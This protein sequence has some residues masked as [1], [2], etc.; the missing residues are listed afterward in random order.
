MNGTEKT[1]PQSDR[2]AALQ[3]VE[4]PSGMVCEAMSCAVLTEG[5]KMLR[6]QGLSKTFRFPPPVTG[7]AVPAS[8]QRGP[9]ARH[10]FDRLRWLLQ[11]AATAT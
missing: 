10:L 4:N 2:F 7:E 9:F 11:K 3:R 6:L 1:G 8:S 5:E